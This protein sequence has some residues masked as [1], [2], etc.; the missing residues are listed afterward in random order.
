M[1]KS[2][3]VMS[4]GRT[5]ALYIEAKSLS[6]DISD[7]LNYDFYKRAREKFEKYLNDLSRSEASEQNVFV[8]NYIQKM[9]KQLDSV[10][11]C[12]N[13]MEKMKFIDRKMPSYLQEVRKRLAQHKTIDSK[14]KSE[15]KKSFVENAARTLSNCNR[16][17][18]VYEKADKMFTKLE[19][20]FEKSAYQTSEYKECQDL[21][22]KIKQTMPELESEVS[23][24]STAVAAIKAQL[25]PTPAGE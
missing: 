14:S 21:W 7:G 9:V 2:S 18:K 24:L 4:L 16:L 22:K 5:D 15:V 10:P 13:V 20:D 12:D 17:T 23:A 19:S 25:S 8:K 6:E 3:G 1:K 11:E